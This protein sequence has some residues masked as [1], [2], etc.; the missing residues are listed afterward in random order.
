[1][2]HLEL[3]IG[4][5]V[6]S[7]FHRRVDFGQRRSRSRFSLPGRAGKGFR[8]EL[9]R[10]RVARASRSVRVADYTRALHKALERRCVDLGF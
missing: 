5:R 6:G 3:G 1:M 8:Q 7:A 9:L 2:I 10:T 4:R